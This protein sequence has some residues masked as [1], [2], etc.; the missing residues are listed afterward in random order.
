MWHLEKV[1]RQ[2]QDYDDDMLWTIAVMTSAPVVVDDG[3][4]FPHL[5]VICDRGRF[6][7][8]PFVYTNWM[9]SVCQK[10]FNLD[11]GISQTGSSYAL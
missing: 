5:V 3:P 11:L 10:R 1:D 7:P 8:I 4:P 6:R 2:Y 9:L